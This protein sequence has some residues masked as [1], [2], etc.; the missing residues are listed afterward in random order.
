MII[1]ISYSLNNEDIL[2][3]PAYSVIGRDYDIPDDVEKFTTLIND[4]KEVKELFTS[5][6]FAFDHK[7]SLVMLGVC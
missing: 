2:N 7:L 4:F 6:P 1:I 3:Y 5:C